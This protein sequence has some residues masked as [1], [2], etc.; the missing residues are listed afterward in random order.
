MTF[1]SRVALH[2]IAIREINA[3]SRKKEAKQQQPNKAYARSR[4]AVEIMLQR[5]RV[6]A[7]TAAA[8]HLPS[9]AV[10]GSFPAWPGPGQ[11]IPSVQRNC[12]AVRL[13][14][15]ANAPSLIHPIRFTTRAQAWCVARGNYN[16]RP[17]K[18][19]PCIDRIQIVV[20][21]RRIN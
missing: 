20:R 2:T 7:G 9:V 1:T 11:L 14:R 16:A 21:Y 17:V 19:A 13:V 6:Q 5:S 15:P 18:V 10:R 8:A 12:K 4:E 3:T